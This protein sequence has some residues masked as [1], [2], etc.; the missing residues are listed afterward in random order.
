[1]RLILAIKTNEKHV[2]LWC[3]R[4][5]DPNELQQHLSQRELTGEKSFWAVVHRVNLFQSLPLVRGGFVHIWME[6]EATGVQPVLGYKM[7]EI[8]DCDVLP[9]HANPQNPSEKKWGEDA[10]CSCSF[11]FWN[12]L[13]VPHTHTR[14][15][16]HER[17][18]TGRKWVKN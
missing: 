14:Q 16:N 4:Y 5:I 2:C 7:N 1:M 9:S 18:T 3:R 13:S 6:V 8:V 10:A 12:I 15:H 11:D 17:Q